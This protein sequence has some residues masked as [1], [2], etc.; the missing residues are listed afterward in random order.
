VED[1]NIEIVWEPAWTPDKTKPKVR[2]LM[3]F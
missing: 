3:G 2:V 1:V